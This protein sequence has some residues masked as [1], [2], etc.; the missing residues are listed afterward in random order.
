[1]V[2]PMVGAEGAPVRILGLVA[3]CRA[4]FVRRRPMSCLGELGLK[5]RLDSVEGWMGSVHTDKKMR[6][7]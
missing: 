4:S 2:E 5:T 6:V 7:K 3:S 1:M